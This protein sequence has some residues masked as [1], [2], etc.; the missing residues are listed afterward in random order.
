MCKKKPALTADL[1]IRRLFAPVFFC[2]FFC[3]LDKVVTKISQ[4]NALT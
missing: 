4:I 3:R 1:H 2:V